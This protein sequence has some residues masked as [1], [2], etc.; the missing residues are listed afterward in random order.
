MCV[1]NECYLIINRSF[2][3]SATVMLHLPECFREISIPL[4][5]YFEY[6][7]NGH[8]TTEVIQCF[9]SVTDQLSVSHQCKC[10]KMMLFHNKTT[11][12]LLRIS[13]KH[14]LYPSDSSLTL[15][16]FPNSRHIYL[17]R[18]SDT[19]GSVHGALLMFS[20]RDTQ[21]VQCCAEMRVH[22]EGGILYFVAIWWS[23]GC[24]RI[25]LP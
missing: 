19:L 16:A 10:G 13:Q 25:K 3:F 24:V 4:C 2:R 20:K 21:T 22:L 5:K 9:L 17:S 7:V 6:T 18:S 23:K 11:E 12:A 15:T 14:I 8:S 1:S